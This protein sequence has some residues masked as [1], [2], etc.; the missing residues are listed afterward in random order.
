MYVSQRGKVNP[1]PHLSQRG[2]ALEEVC[3]LA[4]LRWR[5]LGVEEG[6]AIGDSLQG[7]R[8]LVGEGQTHEQLWKFLI[9]VKKQ[10]LDEDSLKSELT[11]RPA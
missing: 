11:C 10:A 8:T 6:A 4:A 7:G 3:V 9:E 2:F 1:A 5:E